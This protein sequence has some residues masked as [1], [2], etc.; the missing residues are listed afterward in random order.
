MHTIHSG[1][2]V[3]CCHHHQCCYVQICGLPD[4]IYYIYEPILYHHRG[5][6]AKPHPHPTFQ[7]PYQEITP[8]QQATQYFDGLRD[9]REEAIH[10]ESVQKVVSFHDAIPRYKWEEAFLNCGRGQGHG[11]LF[12]EDRT[13][14]AS[15]GSAPEATTGQFTDA[16]QEIS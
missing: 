8:H 9:V 11:T 7:K 14:T 3:H 10:F 16:H 6:V 5:Y 15:V 1:L 13:T 12:E 2:A 4:C